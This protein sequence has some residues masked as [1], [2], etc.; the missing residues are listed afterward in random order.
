M[1]ASSLPNQVPDI[2]GACSVPAEHAVT[3]LGH[4]LELMPAMLAGAR[5]HLRIAFSSGVTL[6][7]FGHVT[8]AP[9]SHRSPDRDTGC[10]A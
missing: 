8:F 4:A 7:H 10:S 3:T 6:L 5:D 9:S 2:I 1:S